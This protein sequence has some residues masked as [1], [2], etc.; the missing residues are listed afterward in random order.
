MRI[1]SA[2]PA[3]AIV[4]LLSGCTGTSLLNRNR[5]DEFAVTRQPPLIIPPDF[6]LTPPA[7]GTSESQQGNTQ[8][9]ALDAMF[10]GPAPRSNG[11]TSMLDD[12][13]QANAELGIRSSAADGK[14]DVLDKGKAVFDIVAAP[15]GDGQNAQA[16]AG[17]SPTG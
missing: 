15:E 2:L 17:Q 16:S 3:A 6:A 1:H 13:G 11:E 14:T 9:Q 4:A 10:G 12:A 8:E 5:P 7:P